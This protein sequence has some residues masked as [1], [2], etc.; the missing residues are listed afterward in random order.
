TDTL[1]TV[2]PI[3]GGATG[4]HMV[5]FHVVTPAAVKAKD[6]IA[7]QCERADETR[8]DVSG[9]PDA[10]TIVGY[11]IANQASAR[12]NIEPLLA[13]FGIFAVDEDGLIKFK[14][15]SDLTSVATVGFDE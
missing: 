2:G 8:Y 11:K 9:I 13:A 1:D 6:I 5:R 10:D 7:D 15:L 14:K 3:S 12:A 4:Y